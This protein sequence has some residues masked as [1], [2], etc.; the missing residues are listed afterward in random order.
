MQ[1]TEATRFTPSPFHS[2]EKFFKACRSSLFR[3]PLQGTSALIPVGVALAALVIGFA[4]GEGRWVLLVPLGFMICVFFWPVPAALGSFAFLV[5]FENAS[6]IP[7]TARSFSVTTA[8]GLA[9]AVILLTVAF[10][11]HRFCRPPRSML[12]WGL[13]VMWAAASTFWA[14]DP[15]VATRGLP[16]ALGLVLL[17]FAT[18]SVRITNDELQWILVAGIVGGAVAAAIASYQ[19][20]HGVFW[21]VDTNRG[22]LVLGSESADPNAFATTLLLPFSLTIGYCLSSCG[23]FKKMLAG[24]IAVLLVLGVL[25]SMSRSAFVALFVIGLIYLYRLR[26]RRKMIAVLSFL[27][28]PLLVVPHSFFARLQDATATRGAGRL[29]IWQAGLVLLK[30]YGVWGAGLDNFADVYSRVAGYASHFMGYTRDS[31]NTYLQIGVDLGVIGLFFFFGAISSQFRALETHSKSVHRYMPLVACEATCWATM[32]CCVFAN[33]IW[34]KVFWLPWM[35]MAVSVR[36]RGI[37]KSS[38][39]VE[40]AS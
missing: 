18:V 4:I 21:A 29:D 13:L 6:A 40:D 37:E 5:P 38:I 27:L 19:F 2:I 12:W 22:S 16:A 14:A 35:L 31:H 39:K 36:L 10:L 28:L 8:V 17:Y 15:H 30:T 32:V 11:G 24:A 1:L 7:G 3:A 33:L 34:R 25:V 20:Y 23:W 26:L 9:A